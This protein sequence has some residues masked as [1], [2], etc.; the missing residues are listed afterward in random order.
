MKRGDRNSAKGKLFC[1]ISNKRPVSE[2][3]TVIPSGFSGLPRGYP[4]KV[5]GLS[6]SVSGSSYLLL[7]RRLVCKRGADTKRSQKQ[8]N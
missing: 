5:L 1:N 6:L 8:G 3:I 7:S 4:V 2:G